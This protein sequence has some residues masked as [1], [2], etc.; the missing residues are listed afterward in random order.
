MTERPVAYEDGTS[1][2]QDQL[3]YPIIEYPGHYGT[4]IGFREESEA[5]IHFCTCMFESIKNYTRYRSKNPRQSNVY[6]HKQHLLSSSDFPIAIPR[7]VSVDQS[8]TVDEIMNK[9][10][11]E[12]QLCHECNE[13]VVPS[14]RYCASMY[15]TVFMQNYG[16]YVNKMH[17]EHGVCNTQSNALIT[18]ILFEE[19]S[20]EVRDLLPENYCQLIGEYQERQ[21]EYYAYDGQRLDP[22]HQ[23]LSDKMNDVGEKLKDA[24]KPVHDAL[25]NEVRRRVGHYEKGSR[26]TSETILSQLVESVYPEYTMHRHY[27]PEF[28]NGLELDIFLEEPRIGIEY[29]GIQHYEIVE[30]WGGEE[31]LE[32]RKA[33]DQQKQELC[34]ENDV[35]LVL[36]RYDEELSEALVKKKLSPYL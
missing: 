13:D 33:R 14:H 35:T 8:M 31:G 5:P 4:F 25:E 21:Q 18:E 10:R 34:I 17:Y 32:K 28:L 9:L 19:C 12:S 29:Q 3:P 7:R 15:G 36:I 16:W 23:L 1:D 20:E 27:Y 22:K 30:H 11:F 24:G 6:A 26:W 2:E